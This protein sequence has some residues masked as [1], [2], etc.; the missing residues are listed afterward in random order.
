MMTLMLISVMMRIWMPSELGANPH[1][2]L[3]IVL[4]ALRQCFSKVWGW[5]KS[6]SLLLFLFYFCWTNF[7]FCFWDFNFWHL[8]VYVVVV[9]LVFCGGYVQ[10]ISFYF[11]VLT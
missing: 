6:L 5:W 1:L 7:N 11:A 9:D 10:M 8:D 3:M 4:Q 2:M